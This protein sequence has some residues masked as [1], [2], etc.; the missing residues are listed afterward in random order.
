MRVL[1]AIFVMSIIVFVA[2]SVMTMD[3][4]QLDTIA[5]SLGLASPTASK[6][7]AAA[8][9][10]PVAAATTT[11]PA[12]AATPSAAIAPASA[13]V[14]A[15]AASTHA[16]RA[17][18][19][20]GDEPAT[21]ATSATASSGSE[22]P[23]QLSA[24]LKSELEQVRD[25]ERQLELKQ[26]SLELIREDIR[27]HQ[28]QI[29]QL[30]SEVDRELRAF[31]KHLTTQ[32]IQGHARDQFAAQAVSMSNEAAPPAEPPMTNRPSAAAA[33]GPQLAVAAIERM[34][35]GDAA[36]VLIQLAKGGQL[37]SVVSLLNAMRE[38]IAA[39]VLADMA[40]IDS[41]LATQLGEQF[42]IRKQTA[43]EANTAPANAFSSVR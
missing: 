28:A 22:P 43:N 5:T 30:R 12:A 27:A 18:F 26:V 19:S 41:A 25:H 38:R 4:A 20:I 35:T 16:A 1:V 37:E 15:T 3:A 42:H 17:K 23:Q 40:Q 34:P 6:P 13:P 7:A 9:S 33:S 21:D 2:T 32:Q 36:R 14:P 39:K 8:T 29:A 10:T 11:A 31:N 24:L